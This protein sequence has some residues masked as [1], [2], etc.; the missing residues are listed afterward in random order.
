MADTQR[1]KIFSFIPCGEPGNS[2]VAFVLP[3]FFSDFEDLSMR[4]S[5][6]VERFRQKRNKRGKNKRGRREA[7]LGA[8]APLSS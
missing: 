4:E 6:C 1:R 7:A 5:D 2:S 8:Q 3:D